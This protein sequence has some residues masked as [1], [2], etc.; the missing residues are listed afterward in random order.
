MGMF[1]DL[2]VDVNGEEIFFVDKEILATFSRKIRNLFRRFTATKIPLKVIFHDFPGGA[3]GFELIMRFCYNNGKIE[4]TPSDIF[5]L[6]CAASFMEVNLIEPSHEHF[7]GIFQRWDWSESLSCLKQCQHLLAAVNSPI[8]LQKFLNLFVE[9]LAWL[10]VSSPYTSPSENS[11]SQSSSDTSTD[12]VKS[13]LSQPTWWFEDLAFLNTNLLSKLIEAMI[14][15]KFN[16]ATISSFLFYYQRSKLLGSPPA[17]KH[18][19]I[20]A[21]TNLL[22]LLDRRSISSRSLFNLF[23]LALCLKARKCSMNKLEALIG[24]KLDQATI[25]DLLVPSPRGKQYM[26]DVNLILRLLNSFFT[27]NR[28]STTRLKKVACLMDLYLAEVA[29]DPHLKP[30]KFIKLATAVPGFARDSQD[31]I[32]LAI[33]MYLKVHRSLSKKAKMKVC[34]LLN[35]NMLLREDLL[36]LAKKSKF[37]PGPGEVWWPSSRAL[38]MAASMLKP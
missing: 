23:G 1:C 30:S 31:G 36:E 11:N 5:L 27:E 24:S 2:E 34:L 26:Y 32:Y 7:E 17:E 22:F 19:I 25:D 6:H 4:I 13:Y 35:H 3:E 38:S 18:K 12:S 16:H 9:R 14:L 21:V 8:M 15:Q 28:L 20:E 37:Q 10:S 29:L 33:D